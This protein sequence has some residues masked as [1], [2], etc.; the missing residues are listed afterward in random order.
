MMRK[1]FSFLVFLMLLLPR[2]AVGEDAAGMD[3]L[4][5]IDQSGSMMGKGQATVRNDPYGKRISALHALEEKFIESSAFGLTNRISVIEFGGRN[6]RHPDFRPQVTVS[7]LLI[8]PQGPGD[9]AASIR[10]YFRD[11]LL[12][13]KNFYRGDTDHAAAFK[14]ALTELEYFRT[15]PPNITP[16]GRPGKRE[17]VVILITDGQSYA[18]GVTPQAMK[19]EIESNT[20]KILSSAKFLNLLVFGF[21]DASRYWQ[22]GWG[23]FWENQATKDPLT[24]MGHAYLIRDHEEAVGK[25]LSL[26]S[27]FIP[28]HTTDIVAASAYAAPAYLKALD[29]TIDFRIPSIPLKDIQILDP[30]GHSIPIIAVD[31]LH[32][33]AQVNHPKPGK[34]QL[35][36]KGA[37]YTVV[38]SPRYEKATLVEPG[39]PIPQN[40]RSPVRYRL[41]GAGPK[42]LFLESP[43]LPP[44]EFRLKV[45]APSGNTIELPMDI[46]TGQGHVKSDKDL[47][48]DQIGSY[49]LIIEGKTKASDGS[50]HVVFRSSLAGGD[51]IAV[52]KAT[53]VTLRLESPSPE[54]HVTMWNGKANLPVKFDFLNER[55]NT[56]MSPQKVLKSKGELKISYFVEGLETNGAPMTLPPNGDHLEV[57][58]PVDLGAPAWD[59]IRHPKQLRLRL[60]PSRDAWRSDISFQGIKGGEYLVTSAI[61][62]QESWLNLGWRVLAVILALIGLIVAW[63]KLGIRWLIQRDDQNNKRSPKLTFRVDINKGTAKSWPLRGIKTLKPP[64]RRVELGDGE[65]WTIQGFKIKRRRSSG[66]DVIV[67]VIYR[68]EKDN[69][70]EILKLRARDDSGM[71]NAKGAIKE[72]EKTDIW[73][74]F[75]LYVGDQA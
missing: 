5:L 34:W 26:T 6:A 40:S 27:E 33:K 50:E 70:K 24:G 63:R 51:V 17:S 65:Y 66:K 47:F 12:P 28:P 61:P 56:V 2:V 67:E 11:G 49:Q 39:S 44:V 14:L 74:E 31:K 42:G 73:P 54:D 58:M 8:P 3:F 25:I 29:F 46:E 43:D 68:T 1:L 38:A 53:P 48:F 21:N 62:A 23:D 41:S 4:Y 64:D 30:D 32:A 15:D 59:S 57:D 45:K 19:N 52:N 20:K 9:D 37:K 10:R 71:G 72:L 36:K 18:A 35:T 60:H 69:A 22:Q 55:N 16:G 75:I 7:R 13:V